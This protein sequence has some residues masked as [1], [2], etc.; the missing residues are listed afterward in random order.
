MFFLYIFPT[1]KQTNKQPQA[2]LK[3]W[4]RLLW[5]L[6]T[7]GFSPLELFLNLTPTQSLRLVSTWPCLAW[8]RCMMGY[9]THRKEDKTLAGLTSLSHIQTLL[10]MDGRHKHEEKQASGMEKSLWR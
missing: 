7:E 1:F 3:Q 9:V 2:S 5:E 6:K 10:D 8:Q 4:C